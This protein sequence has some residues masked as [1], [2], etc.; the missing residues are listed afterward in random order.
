VYGD[1]QHWQPQDTFFKSVA[2]FMNVRK[3]PPSLLYLLATLAPCLLALS[4]LQ[5][6]TFT[7]PLSRAL[8]TY[9]RVPMF[10]YLLQWVWA[11][12]CGLAVAAIH[13]TSIAAHFQSRAETFL[14][15]PAPVFGGTLLDVYLC[16]ALGAVA[17]YLPCRWYA[18][19]KARRKDL[20]LL[21][22]L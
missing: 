6:R 5:G 7:N 13:G 14:G 10:F 15:A 2:S 12:G 19:V 20:V 1:P 18:G 11:H 3:Y 16:W 22:Y 8:I 4:F 17:L 21:R 9:G